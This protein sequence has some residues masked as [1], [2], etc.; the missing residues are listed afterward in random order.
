MPVNGTIWGLPA[1][2][3]VRVTSACNVPVSIG[4]NTTVI[5]QWSPGA[6][7]LGLMGQLFHWSKS[8]PLAPVMTILVM[9]KGTVPVFVNV[10]F[11][12]AVRP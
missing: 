2:L 10:T 9:S 1:A 7:V 8:L 5:V 12:G 3:S 4:A 11:C 6:R